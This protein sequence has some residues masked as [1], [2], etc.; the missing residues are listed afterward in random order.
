MKTI[1]DELSKQQEKY[2]D[3]ENILAMNY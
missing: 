1:E 3:L 2:N